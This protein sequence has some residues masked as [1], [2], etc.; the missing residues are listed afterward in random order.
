VKRTRVYIVGGLLRV[1]SARAS[2]RQ[3]VKRDMNAAES[4]NKAH[5]ALV[6]SRLEY[7]RLSRARGRAASTGQSTLFAIDARPYRHV[8][9]LL[10]RVPL[11]H[12]RLA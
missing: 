12:T 1:L 5:S 7:Y 2:G 9:D 11:R 4:Q 6:P 3:V 10:E 8:I